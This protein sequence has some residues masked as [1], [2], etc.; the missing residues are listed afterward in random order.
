[1]EK[2]VES[3]MLTKESV[4]GEVKLN[5]LGGQS[6]HEE[7]ESAAKV[8]TSHNLFSN[9]HLCN[10]CKHNTHTHTHTYIYYKTFYIVGIKN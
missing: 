4:N 9:F 2:Y 6:L 1:M 3:T 10:V 7:L 5:P 8:C